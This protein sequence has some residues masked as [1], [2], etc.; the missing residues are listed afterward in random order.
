[1]VL[2]PRWNSKRLL[3]VVV[4]VVEVVVVMT[5]VVVV[6]VVVVMMV[7][8]VVVFK[9]QPSIGPLLSSCD[10]RDRIDVGHGFVGL[11]GYGE[12]VR[13]SRL[14][15]IARHGTG[16]PFDSCRSS[17]N[18][19]GKAIIT[20][21]HELTNHVALQI[22]LLSARGLREVAPELF[23]RG[24]VQPYC[25]CEVMGRDEPS[26]RTR[27][28]DEG[29]S[30]TWDESTEMVIEEGE[31]LIFMVNYKDDGTEDDLIG[32]GPGSA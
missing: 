17:S 12:H 31:S 21:L 1:M 7:V 30:P 26:F 6:E 9:D 10:V 22:R 16:C 13:A 2:K 8:A 18:I 25:L 27:A 14:G 3:L 29:D 20:F 15:G 19:F 32:R 23:A 28:V 24:A 4:V 5:V 11:H